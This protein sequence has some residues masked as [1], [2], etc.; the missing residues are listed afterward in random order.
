MEFVK[1][2]DMKRHQFKYIKGWFV[3]P[4]AIS[5]SRRMELLYAPIAISVHFMWWH[6]QYTFPERSRYARN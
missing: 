4:L 1:G 6:Y 3:F 2:A 5:I